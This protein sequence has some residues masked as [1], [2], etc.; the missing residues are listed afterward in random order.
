[1]GKRVR[2]RQLA[3]TDDTFPTPET[4]EQGRDEMDKRNILTFA[5]ILAIL[6]MPVTFS[7]PL[8]GLKDAHEVDTMAT[9]FVW[10][11]SVAAVDTMATDFVW[12]PKAD[13]I[14]T[15]ATEFL[16]VSTQPQ[17]VASK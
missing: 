4:T 16:W 12:L 15:M 6:L 13:A 17:I 5:S 3:V 2:K 8:A 9:E 11:P 14:D 1:V 10:T 7:G